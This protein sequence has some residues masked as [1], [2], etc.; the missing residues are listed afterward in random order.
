M[1][2]S[3]DPRENRTGG[4]AIA[5]RVNG[6]LKGEFL[7]KQYGTLAEVQA[8]LPKLISIYNVERPH[9]SLDLLTPS[10]AHGQEDRLKRRWKT[11]PFKSKNPDKVQDSTSTP[12]SSKAKV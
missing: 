4:P 3:G 12:A 2:E 9:L 8:V 1:T 10:E 7:Q 5:E 11:Y 6:I